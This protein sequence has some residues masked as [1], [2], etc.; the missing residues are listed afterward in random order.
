MATCS[1][2]LAIAES[3]LLLIMLVALPCVLDSGHEHEMTRV[4]EAAALYALEY[5]SEMRATAQR[6]RRIR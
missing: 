1:W 6:F 3:V 4:V 2:S 5:A